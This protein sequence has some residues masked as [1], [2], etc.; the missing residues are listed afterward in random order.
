MSSTQYK[1]MIETGGDAK[2][3]ETTIF[4]FSFDKDRYSA[5]PYTRFYDLG[6]Y[7]GALD[8]QETYQSTLQ[9]S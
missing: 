6:F 2:I 8:T 9:V 5:P 7:E 4:V 3:L 1:I